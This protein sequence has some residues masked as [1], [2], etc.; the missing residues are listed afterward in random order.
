MAPP[1]TL[2]IPACTALETARFDVECWGINSFQK[3]DFFLNHRPPCQRRL[4]I[5]PTLQ[6]T[7]SLILKNPYSNIS[8]CHSPSS[9]LFT[10]TPR[11]RFPS[12]DESKFRD[13]DVD[14]NGFLT[15]VEFRSFTHPEDH[16][17]MHPNFIARLVN[18]TDANG[19]GAIDLQEFLKHGQSAGKSSLGVRV[20]FDSINRRLYFLYFYP[21]VWL[22]RSIFSS[23]KWNT[24]SIDWSTLGPTRSF[25]RSSVC[26]LVLPFICSSIRSAKLIKR[27][28]YLLNFATVLLTLISV[29]QKNRHQTNPLFVKLAH[30]IEMLIPIV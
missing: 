2:D 23:F 4:S 11:P 3:F 20:N 10:P 15:A 13:A 24:G 21:F 7:F 16:L 8:S 12:E 5:M 29:W 17:H 30:F 27:R 9:F 1:T 26:S 25:V 6:D 22:I 14:G 18:E 28:R 19:D